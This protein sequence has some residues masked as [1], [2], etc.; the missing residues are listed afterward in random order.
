[1]SSTS[2]GINRANDD[3]LRVVWLNAVVK[4]DRVAC[5]LTLNKLFDCRFFN[6]KSIHVHENCSVIGKT[7]EKFVFDTV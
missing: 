6:V 7:E 1:M 2:V 3:T 4:F 5:F